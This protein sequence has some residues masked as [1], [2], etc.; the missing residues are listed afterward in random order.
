[1]DGVDSRRGTLYLIA[2]AAPAAGGLVEL[3][4]LAQRGGWQVHVV[5]TP[6]GSRFVDGEA[7][8]ALTGNRVLSE[9]RT[10]D[11][12]KGLPPADGVIVAPATFN[13]MNKWANGIAD[14]FAVGLLCEVM[15]YGVPTVA[16]PQLKEAL[17]HHRAF[18]HSM[19]ELEEMGV[20]ILFNPDAPPHARMPSWVEILAELE[21]LV[22][23]R[24]A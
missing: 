13:T 21:R 2:C 24:T 11:Q 12:P 7:M 19:G 1:M 5:T 10:P 20:R 16:V 22:G 6:M 18:K 8:E 4:K 14:T 9:Y 17:A 23:H 3:V 15:G